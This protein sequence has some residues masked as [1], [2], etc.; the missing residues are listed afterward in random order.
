M[1]NFKFFNEGNIKTI[2][3]CGAFGLMVV[4]LDILYFKAELNEKSLDDYDQN[5]RIFF[6]AAMDE[7]RELHQKNEELNTKLE[8]SKERIS[9][10]DASID[11]K[12]KRWA[13]IK[14]VRDAIT[15]TAKEAPPILE[16]TRIASSVVDYADEYDVP[17]PLILG[18][19]RRESHFKSKA[20]SHAGALGLM[21]VI[22][23]TGAEISADIGKRRYHLFNIQDNIRFGTYYI[24]K[25]LDRFDGDVELAVR[26]YNCG[27]TYVEKVVAEEYKQY[28]SETVKYLEAVM[29][30]KE[31]YENLGL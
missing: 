9:I 12:D 17:V 8:A 5:A 28:P 25:M 19:M 31:E 21:Q 29:R 6:G 16:L 20:V 15:E 26:A 11:S 1:V 2:L 13:T 24:R 10:L 14:Q 30:F 23:A 27:P 7:I 18:M 4:A 22:P 3:V